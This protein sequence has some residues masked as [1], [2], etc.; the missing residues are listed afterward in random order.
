MPIFGLIFIQE[1]Y[2][3]TILCMHFC[4]EMSLICILLWEN[5][6]TLYITI[7][8]YKFIIIILIYNTRQSRSHPSGGRGEAVYRSS[9]F[10]GVNIWNYLLK[11]IPTNVFY[12]RIN[13]VTKSYLLN[14]NIIYR[15]L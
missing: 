6:Q 9:S 13:K 7:I 5:L 2:L 1:L 12:N 4:L 11:H 8:N 15:L 3:F 10:H 14:N